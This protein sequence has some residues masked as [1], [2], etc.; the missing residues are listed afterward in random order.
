M[1]LTFE[2]DGKVL[3]SPSDEDIE[4]GFASIEADRPGNISIL[5][6]SREPG[7]LCAVGNPKD[8]YRLEIETVLRRAPV[9]RAITIDT[10]IPQEK[11]LHAF[12]AF[13]HNGKNWPAKFEWEQLAGPV[14]T[15]VIKRQMV[16][17]ITTFVLLYFVLKYVFKLF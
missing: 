2:V 15:A 1:P 10:H 16:I 12:K 7:T 8:G 3:H 11:A 5:K 9:R 13:A 4:A 14:H 6:I 17:Y